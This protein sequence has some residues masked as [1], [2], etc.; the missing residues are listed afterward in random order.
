MK[1][2]DIMAVATFDAVWHPLRKGHAVNRI[3][4]LDLNVMLK[5]PLR[6]LW[7]PSTNGRVKRHFHFKKCSR[8]TFYWRLTCKACSHSLRGTTYISV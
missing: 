6:L 4:T 8:P 3:A 7:D 5:T 1:N 2:S